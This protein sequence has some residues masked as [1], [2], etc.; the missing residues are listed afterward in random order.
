MSEALVASTGSD[1]SVVSERSPSPVS[2]PAGT[3]ATDAAKSPRTTL[4]VIRPVVARRRP[5]VAVLPSM[6]TVH[7]ADWPPHTCAY[8]RARIR[9]RKAASVTSPSSSTEI[10][11]C[12]RS[13]GTKLA[14][15]ASVGSR[16]PM[17]R[18]VTV[19]A[20]CSALTSC[21][22]VGATDTLSPRPKAIG[23]AGGGGSGGG[24]GGGGGGRGGDGG[25]GD[26]GGA[27][28]RSKLPM[29]PPHGSNG[30]EARQLAA[31]SMRM[32]AWVVAGS[33]VI[34]AVDSSRRRPPNV[35]SLAEYLRVERTVCPS[36]PTSVKCC[37]IARSGAAR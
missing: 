37:G 27:Y 9:S 3:L 35:S 13:S 29:T 6:V 15:C 12:T 8:A 11:V 19:S 21:R 33:Y 20:S 23:A 17:T 32:I 4:K 26:G 7:A 22:S 5:E 18:V 36:H 14:A 34:V 30:R 24:A 28:A 25:G 1:S 31:P 16:A 2:S 10:E